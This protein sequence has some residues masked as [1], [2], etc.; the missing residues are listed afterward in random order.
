MRANTQKVLWERA[1][2]EP[3]TGCWLWLGYIDRGGYGRISWSGRN[4]GSHQI[5]YGLHHGTVPTGLEVDHLCRVRSCVNPKHL[6]AVPR[7][8][9]VLRG[10]SPA[11][12]SARRTHCK[13][14]HAY[15]SENTYLS[16][17][18]RGCK[19]CLVA[20]DGKHLGETS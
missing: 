18:G 7:R 20:W 10:Q 1:L 11:A 15:T 9:N 5:A 17:V 2:P 16:Q 12:I 14:G 13:N 8:V 4:V 19:A 6:E 3:N